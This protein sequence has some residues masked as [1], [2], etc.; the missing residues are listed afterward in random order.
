MEDDA[1][2][3]SNEISG[4]DKSD[5]GPKQPS[6]EAKYSVHKKDCTWRTG[7]VRSSGSIYLKTLLAHVSIIPP[8]E[9]CAALRAVIIS[10]VCCH[11]FP[12]HVTRASDIGHAYCREVEKLLVIEE[13]IVY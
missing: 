7:F 8:Q 6:S 4:R 13:D 10:F 11:G 12:A 5:G 2:L 9:R 1:P 3:Q